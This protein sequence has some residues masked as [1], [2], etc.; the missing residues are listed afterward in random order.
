ML[1]GLARSVGFAVVA[2]GT[3]GEKGATLPLVALPV[4]GGERP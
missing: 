4:F 1:R 3:D 2:P